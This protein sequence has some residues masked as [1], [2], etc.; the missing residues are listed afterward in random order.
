[1]SHRSRPRFRGYSISTERKES[2]D[3]GNE[4]T[5][6]AIA[7]GSMNRSRVEGGSVGPGN[8]EVA[9]GRVLIPDR[10]LSP[11]C[12]PHFASARARTSCAHAFDIVLR[13][14]LS[15]NRSDRR[16]A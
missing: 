1:V 9:A 10:E 8:R 16:E 11:G 12:S 3:A 6:R 2:T 7:D 5:E 15:S 13:H 4:T 14:P